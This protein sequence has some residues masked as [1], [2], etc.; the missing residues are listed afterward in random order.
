MD[1]CDLWFLVYG[2]AAGARD[3]ETSLG[4]IGAAPGGRARNPLVASMTCVSTFGHGDR[5]K[6]RPRIRHGFAG[7]AYLLTPFVG[8]QKPCTRI[9]R[10]TGKGTGVVRRRSQGFPMIPPVRRG[11]MSPARSPADGN[12]RRTSPDGVRYPPNTTR[13]RA[14]RLEH[15]ACRAQ[16]GAAPPP[17]LR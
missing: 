10:K 11:D 4:A 5:R 7:G 15:A 16:T 12:L 1:N 17:I 8:H 9:L 13:R 3:D 2:S 6:H 14:A